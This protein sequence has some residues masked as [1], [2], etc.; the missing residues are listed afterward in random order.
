MR[1]QEFVRQNPECEKLYR[2]NNLVSLTNELPGRKEGE[3]VD[4]KRQREYQTKAMYE[5]PCLESDLNLPIVFF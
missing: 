2:T 1:L 5:P 4:E 3:A